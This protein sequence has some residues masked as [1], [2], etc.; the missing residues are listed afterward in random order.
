M[1]SLKGQEEG[2]G[3]KL[4][5]TWCY[6]VETSLARLSM[7]EQGKSKEFRSFRQHISLSQV[8]LYQF[9]QKHLDT[10]V[11]WKHVSGGGCLEVRCL[12]ARCLCTF[13]SVGV[14]RHEPRLRLYVL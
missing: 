11:K 7:A 5:V 4:L 13:S 2:K 14:I 9:P 6:F 10:G 3:S 1:E 8:T 12:R